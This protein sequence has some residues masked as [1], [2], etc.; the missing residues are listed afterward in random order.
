M[1]AFFSM[2]DGRKRLHREV[3]EQL[4]EHRGVLRTAIPAAGRRRAHGRSSA[5]AIGAVRPARPRRLAYRDLW[6]EIRGRLD[7]ALPGR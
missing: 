7:T 2:V 6:L 4:A 3:M 1:L 5:T